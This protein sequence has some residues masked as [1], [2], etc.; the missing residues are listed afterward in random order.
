VAFFLSEVP[1]FSLSCPANSE[2][3]HLKGNPE[4]AGLSSLQFFRFAEV[5][6]FPRRAAAFTADEA[7]LGNKFLQLL[8]VIL[9]VVL[10][11]L[12]KWFTLLGHELAPLVPSVKA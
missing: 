12:A 1:T 10:V 3:F 2:Q 4:L 5:V 9:D 8:E 7:G 6:F 11:P